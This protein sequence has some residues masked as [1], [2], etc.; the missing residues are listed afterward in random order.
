LHRTLAVEGKREIDLFTWDQVA[1]NTLDVYKKLV[2][3]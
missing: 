1:E 3:L 2:V